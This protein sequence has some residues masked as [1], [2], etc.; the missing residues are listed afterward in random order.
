MRKRASWIPAVAAGSLVLLYIPLLWM[1]GAS[2]NAAPWGLKWEGFTLQWYGALLED[3][4]VREA[5]ANSLIL[6]LAS[7]AIATLLGTA[8]ALGL[9]RYPW[10]RW[11]R[12]GIG[13]CL[14]VPVMVPDIVFAI[15]LLL[16]FRASSWAASSF[17]LGMPTLIL[18]H[19][20]FQLAFVALTVRARLV[21]IGVTL[22]EA[23]QDLYGSRWFVF[24]HVTVPLLLPSIVAGALL[25]FTLS[26]DDAVISIFV[27][28]TTRTVPTHILTEVRKG[29]SPQ[30]H[31]LATSF[32]LVTVVLVMGMERMLRPRKG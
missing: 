4:A 11:L 23:A 7:T 31:A 24:W 25:A 12:S 15:G 2:L 19:V 8:L 26:L 30:L 10:P 32:F 28:G 5:I 22:H 1:V 9:E 17:E 27:R 14:D 20:S 16:A 13:L 3:P 6:A 21:S 29:I 18:G